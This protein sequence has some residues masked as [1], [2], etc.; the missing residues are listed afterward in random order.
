MISDCEM[1]YRL[2][3]CLI[4]QQKYQEAVGVLESIADRART[5]KVR[6]ALARLYASQEHSAGGGS[7]TTRRRPPSNAL[8]N[9]RL[10]CGV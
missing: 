1:R 4:R 5:P 9:Y 7:S 6:A 10:V 3:R 8:A 2:H